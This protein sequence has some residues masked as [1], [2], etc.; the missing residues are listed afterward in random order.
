MKQEYATIDN[1]PVHLSVIN[2][3]QV[4]T[5]NGRVLVPTE[6]QHLVLDVL[7]RAH[8]SAGHPGCGQTAQNLRSIHLEYKTATIE[9]RAQRAST[10]RPRAT[11]ATRTHSGLPRSTVR[12]ST[13]PFRASSPHF[14]GSHAPPLRPRPAAAVKK[15]TDVVTV[16]PVSRPQ[17]SGDT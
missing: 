12:A 6:A 10:Q 8:D 14:S 2:D 15:G 3:T 13:P 16:G 4:Y 1:H 7:A 9:S 17:R 5:I 11:P